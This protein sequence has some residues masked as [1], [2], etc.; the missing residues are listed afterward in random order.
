M[1]KNQFSL[2]GFI[3]DYED[4]NLTDEQVIDGF[5]K[6]LD[7]GAIYHLQGSYYRMAQRLIDE[8]YITP[9]KEAK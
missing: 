8:G 7:T 4:G 1:S 5:Q 2:V 3:M 9:T 6:L